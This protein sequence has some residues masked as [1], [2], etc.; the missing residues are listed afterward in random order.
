MVEEREWRGEEEAKREE[1]HEGLRSCCRV[2]IVEKR[3][4]AEKSWPTS[5]LSRYPKQ[6]LST[7]SRVI[8][9]RLE[10]QID[11]F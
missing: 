4:G 5:Y 11:H 9:K 1:D 2:A 6:F 10:T 3:K 8:L 7:A